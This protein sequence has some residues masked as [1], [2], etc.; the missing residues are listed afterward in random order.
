[1]NWTVVVYGGPMLL[2]TLWWFASAH[3]WFKGPK[4]NIDHLML[5]REGNGVDGV[6]IAGAGA[7]A[8]AGGDEAYGP[9]K[10]GE[11]KVPVDG[12]G[13]RGSVDK[14]HVVEE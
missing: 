7:G 11:E 13:D 14:D 6:V 12:R 8:G 10:G 4:V 9:A 5:G 3:K 2:V 1:M